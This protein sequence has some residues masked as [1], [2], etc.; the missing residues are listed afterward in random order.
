M[1]LVVV[2]NPTIEDSDI[3]SLSC[4]GWLNFNTY[5]GHV[6]ILSIALSMSSLIYLEKDLFSFSKK[7]LL[8][9][10]WTRLSETT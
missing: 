8:F 5:F 9:L 7:F 4:H 6:I 10:P 2:N 1:H 3:F